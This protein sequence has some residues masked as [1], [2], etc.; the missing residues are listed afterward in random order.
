MKKASVIWLVFVQ[1]VLAFEWLHSGWGKWSAP[2]FMDNIG[3]SL[4]GFAAKTPYTAYASFLKSSVVP[5]AELFGNTI[6][7]GELAVG[8]AL[9]LGGILLLTQ[10]R[11]PAVATW[12]LAIA[13]FGGALMNLNFFLASGWSSPSTWGVNMVMG[14]ALFILGVYYLTNRRQLAS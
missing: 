1:W 7:T 5:N 4:E 14:L 11:L 3:K 9:A 8:V 10:K 12:L 13:C 6:R 2:G